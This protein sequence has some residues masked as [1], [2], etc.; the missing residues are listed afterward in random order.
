VTIA[1]F[2]YLI[3]LSNLSILRVPDEG[4]FRNTSCTLNLI[5]TFDIVDGVCGIFILSD[6]VQYG[7]GTV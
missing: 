1:D 2:G 5:S 4:Y 7:M 6:L 3:W